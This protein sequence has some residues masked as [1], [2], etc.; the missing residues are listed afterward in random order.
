MQLY[1]SIINAEKRIKKYVL[2]T[3][4]Y[5]SFFFSKYVDAQVFLKCEHLQH[6]G[7]FKIRGAINKLLSVN[8]QNSKN[9]TNTNT[10]NN[11]K[12]NNTNTDINKEKRNVFVAS[13]GNHGLGV[14]HAAKILNFPVTVYLPAKVDP[15][16]LSMIEY[17]SPKIKRIKGDCLNAELIAKKDAANE[18]AI[19]ISPYNDFDVISGQG[20]IGIELSE[21]IKDLDAVFVAVG[22]GGLISGIAGY[23]KN[24]NKNIEIVGC[25]A[26]NSKVMYECVQAAKI[27]D[28]DEKE[29]ISD[30]TMG[31]I[32][33]NSITLDYCKKYIDSKVI[34]SENKILDA[35]KLIVKEERWIIEG[36][37]ALTVA[38]LMQEKERYK[39][40]KIALILCGR[41][42]SIDRFLTT[43]NLSS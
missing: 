9:I 3:P 42:I 27:V 1:E 29:T 37:A 16:K 20:T 13:T 2:K 5:Q 40:K 22:G 25:W 21:Q 4:C 7:S 14:L 34:V 19:F 36:A 6:T 33:E 28:V 10:T 17:Y 30:A 11:N 15:Q 41:N 8:I 26:E 24:I 38:S 12:N 32:E 43:L 23:L 18:N 35:I 31:G 39:N